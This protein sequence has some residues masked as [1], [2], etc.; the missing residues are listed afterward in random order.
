MKSTDR[1]ASDQSGASSVGEERI[2]KDKEQ[3]QTIT[4]RLNPAEKERSKAD[5]VCRRAKTPGKKKEAKEKRRE[6]S[7]KIK[8]L[9]RKLKRAE[10]ILQK[11]P[12]L[13]ELLKREQFE[14]YLDTNMSVI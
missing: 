13:M 3:K 12:H 9:R 11:S 1:E 2:V 14:K 6:L 4:L 5:N 10:K 7:A 8:P